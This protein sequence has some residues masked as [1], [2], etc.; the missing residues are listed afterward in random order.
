MSENGAD[1]ENRHPCDRSGQPNTPRKHDW[2]D[3]FWKAE[4]AFGMSLFAQ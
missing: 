2:S 4:E 1:F 3:L